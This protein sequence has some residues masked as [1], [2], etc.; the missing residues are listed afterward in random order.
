M[1]FGLTST[2]LL[3]DENRFASKGAHLN[4]K[5]A[6]KARAAIAKLPG[7]RRTYALTMSAFLFSLL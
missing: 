5:R 7:I 1:L 4:L 2:S 3:Q 6:E